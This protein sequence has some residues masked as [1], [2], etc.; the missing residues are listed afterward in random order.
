M[1]RLDQLDL[2]ILELLQADARISNA[3]IARKVGLAPSATLERIRKLERRGLIQGYAARLDAAALGLGLLAFVFVR[4]NESVGSPQTARRLAAL[5]EVQEIHHIAGEDCFLVKVRAANTQALGEL[6]S[7]RFGRIPSITSTRTTIVL[8]TL[9]EVSSLPIP[10][11]VTAA[12]G[13]ASA[14]KRS[15][16]KG[17]RS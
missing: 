13:E 10:C 5:P 8:R 9:K 4:S 6:L 7:S 17:K 14:G 15:R 3:A 2:R 11:V 16:R 1:N 12:H